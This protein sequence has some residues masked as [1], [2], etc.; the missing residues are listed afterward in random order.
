MIASRTRRNLAAAYGIA[1]TGD[2]VIDTI[3]LSYVIAIRYW[4]WPTAAALAV[5]APF[6]LIDLVFSRLEHAEDTAGWL[7][8]ACARCRLVTITVI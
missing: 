2:D 8:P 4:N 5:L 1:V 7:V 3:L 6:L